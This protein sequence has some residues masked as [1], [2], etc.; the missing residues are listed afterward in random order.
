MEEDAD[1]ASPGGGERTAEHLSTALLG[2]EE[3]G[4][5]VQG[6]ALAGAVGAE[7]GEDFAARQGDAEGL[8]AVAAGVPVGG[9]MQDD[10]RGL[11]GR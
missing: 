7:Q 11:R 3:P 9:V 1:V 6:G 8:D 4:D 5:Q 10:R 2:L